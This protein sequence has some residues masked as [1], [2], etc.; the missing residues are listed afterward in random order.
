MIKTSQKPKKFFTT[1]ILIFCTIFYVPVIYRTTINASTDIPSHTIILEKSFQASLK[2]TFIRPGHSMISIRFMRRIP[3]CLPA[4][5][6]INTQVVLIGILDHSLKTRSI[7][8]YT[9]STI[10]AA[11]IWFVE[12]FQVTTF[13]I[14]C[15]LYTSPSPRDRTRSRMPSSA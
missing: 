11:I 3:N 13:H 5:S 15:L 7:T 1:K 6:H 12:V 10:V 8:K 9:R 4:N 2:A 14:G